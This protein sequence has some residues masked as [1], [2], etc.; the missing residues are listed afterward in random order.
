[1]T[2]HNVRTSTRLSCVL[3]HIDIH[4]RACPCMRIYTS[5][6]KLAL[7]FILIHYTTCIYILVYIHRI[8]C[9]G[10]PSV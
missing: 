2:V 3:V 4:R 10:Y 5:I 8:N 6:Q 1:M 7:V 9:S